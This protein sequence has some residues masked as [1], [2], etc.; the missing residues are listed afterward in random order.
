MNKYQIS[1]EEVNTR[2]D[3]I[4]TKIEQDISRT[5]IQRLLDE[6]NILVNGKK[7]KPSYKVVEGDIITITKEE[8]K[9]I[10]LLPQDIP[11]DIIYEDKDMLIVNKAKGMV[12][13]PGARKSRW[14]TC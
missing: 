7:I 14:Y 13:H 6:G 2:I 5:S 8:P 9:E 1:K 11:I 3:K 12:V 4:I 10:D